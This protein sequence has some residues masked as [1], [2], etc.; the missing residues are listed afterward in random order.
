MTLVPKHVATRVQGRDKG[1]YAT[2]LVLLEQTTRPSSCRS[3]PPPPPEQG[4]STSSTPLM[5][6]W[7][8][9]SPLSPK[10]GVPSRPQGDRDTGR[11]VFR[12]PAFFSRLLDVGHSSFR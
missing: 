6:K 7:S 8:P 2:R 11:G 10:V 5:L 4:F 1:G 9:P 12:A 3:R